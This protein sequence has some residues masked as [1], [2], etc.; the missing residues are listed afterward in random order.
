MLL[1]ASYTH[2]AYS[3]AYAV[4]THFWERIG[5][6]KFY[7]RDNSGTLGLAHRPESAMSI[8][9]SILKTADTATLLS[10]PVA[11]LF[12]PG[13]FNDPVAI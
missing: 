8:R 9:I 11:N 12:P 3:S 4:P 5:V 6:S 13:L 1:T 2:Y 10:R 7:N